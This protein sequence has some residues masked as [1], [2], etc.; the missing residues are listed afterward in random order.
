MLV[1]MG[2][3]ISFLSVMI[4]VNFNHVSTKGYTIKFLEVRQQE[5][6]EE[7]ELL[8]KDLLERKALSELSYTEKA[9]SMVFPRDVQFVR[10]NTALAL[11]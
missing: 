4:L 2:L 8:K 5:L 9:A 10:G 6:Y 1:G 7:N 3:V 11:K